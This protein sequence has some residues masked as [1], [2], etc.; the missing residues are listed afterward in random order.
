MTKRSR[1]ED[2]DDV[3]YNV[4]NDIEY[5]LGSGDPPP[6]KKP[7]TPKKDASPSNNSAIHDGASPPTVYSKFS[8]NTQAR[9]PRRRISFSNDQKRAPKSS[10][11]MKRLKDL[12]SMKEPKMNVG[13]EIVGAAYI[14][15]QMTTKRP[16]DDHHN[17]DDKI[18]LA[19]KQAVKA[20]KL[21]FLAE[22]NLNKALQ[23]LS[24]TKTA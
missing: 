17:D 6:K 3:D 9:V 8:S 19:M 12:C 24:K 11:V 13:I 14:L 4:N 15:K 20:T 22:H 21:L 18:G 10:I 2:D 16:D 1:G 23:Q 5:E 7:K